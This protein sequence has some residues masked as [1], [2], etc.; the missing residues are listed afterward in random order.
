MPASEN[1]KICWLGDL[2]H[3]I[4]K[5]L[6]VGAEYQLI[7]SRSFNQ[8]L[9]LEQINN[10]GSTPPVPKLWGAPELLTELF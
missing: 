6:P 1:I 7:I 10:W 3:K 2:H 5:C 9:F 8:R 4:V